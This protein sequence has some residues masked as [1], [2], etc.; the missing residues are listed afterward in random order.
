VV[1]TNKDIQNC[2]GGMK[3]WGQKVGCWRLFHHSEGHEVNKI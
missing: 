1:P 2:G 3:K